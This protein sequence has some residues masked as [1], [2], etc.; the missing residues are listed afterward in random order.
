MLSLWF[1]SSELEALVFINKPN[2]CME[3]RTYNFEEV[4]NYVNLKICAE[5]GKEKGTYI[6]LLKKSKK[7][8]NYEVEFN[9][10]GKN[11]NWDTEETQ[12]AKAEP[13]QTQKVV[14]EESVKSIEDTNLLKPNTWIYFVD[15][16]N[17]SYVWGTS[18][19]DASHFLN[20]KNNMKNYRYDEKEKL[21]FYLRKAGNLERKYIRISEQLKNKL[22]PKNNS[23][24]SV[25][26]FKKEY[27]TK[28]LNELIDEYVEDKKS[29][30]DFLAYF[31]QKQ[32]A[33]TPKKKVKV[34]KKEPKQEERL[35]LRIKILIMMHLL[36]R[37]QRA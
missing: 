3:N 19:F 27:T 29:K 12:I 8:K 1:E 30:E 7:C 17:P 13:S 31:D 2:A 35:N 16:S 26:E 33:T 6:G 21:F 28:I 18:K 4:T 11:F 24:I 20:N 5:P 37:L 25:S 34:V 15:I 23:R 10:D 22:F 32:P 9:Y 14:K 36:L